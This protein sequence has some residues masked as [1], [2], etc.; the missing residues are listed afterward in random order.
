MTGLH[1]VSDLMC[2]RCGAPVGWMYHAAAHGREQY[3]IS[4]AVLEKCWLRR[5][6]GAPPEHASAGSAG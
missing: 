3:K 5:V 1:V 4:R 2:D 6:R